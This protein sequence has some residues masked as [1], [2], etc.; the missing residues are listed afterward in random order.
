MA[1]FDPVAPSARGPVAPVAPFAPVAPL[2][3]VGPAG[4]VWLHETAA[5]LAW[6]WPPC[7]GSM[8]RTCPWLESTHAWNVPVLSGMDA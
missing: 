2:A 7:D 1:P 6:H 8:I 5:S 4:P 3:P